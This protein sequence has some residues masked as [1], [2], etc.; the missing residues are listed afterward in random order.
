MQT[1]NP[2]GA[3]QAIRT[4]NQPKF[5]LQ[6]ELWNV[7]VTIPLFQAIRDIQIYAKIVK[8]LCIKKPGRKSKYLPKINVIGK[9]VDLILGRTIPLK[10]DDLGNLVITIH[11]NNISISNTLIDQ[12][13]TI[14]IMRKDILDSIGLKSRETLTILELV[15]FS[16]Y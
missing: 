14:N 8:E 6:Q 15:D 3:T 2:L 4:E 11:I 16:P 5:D 13:A 12:E 10:Y 1:S 7:C 9:L